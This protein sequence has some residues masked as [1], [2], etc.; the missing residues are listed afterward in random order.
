MHD[1]SLE[2]VFLKLLSE[3]ERLDLALNEG[4]MDLLVEQELEDK[5]VAAMQK[6]IDGAKKG[7]ANSIRQSRRACLMPALFWIIFQNWVAL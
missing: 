1:K 4:R 7:F 5:D 2:R 6:S 3:E